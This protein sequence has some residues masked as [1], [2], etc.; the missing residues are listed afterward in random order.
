MRDVYSKA[1]L[2]IAATGAQSGDIGLFFGRDIELLTPVRIEATW[3][4]NHDLLHWPS[5]GSYLF[6]FHNV[7]VWKAIDNAPLN[8]RAWVAQERFLSKRTLHFTQSLLFWECP[9]SFTSENDA[10]ARTSLHSRLTSL[11]TRLNC[12]QWPDLDVDAMQDI[13]LDSTNNDTKLR[14]VYLTW[15]QFLYHYTSCG[16]TR[17]SDIL[18]ALV[19]VADE[20][21]HAMSD[22]MVA[23]LW[24]TR[25]IEELCWRSH[26]DTSRPIV[27]RAPSWSW[28]SLSNPVLP[29][30]CTSSHIPH[31]MAAVI[32]LCISK[33]SSGEV[34]QGSALIECRPI[35]ATVQYS[36]A[37]GSN[38]AYNALGT[39]DESVW[40]FSEKSNPER[41]GLIEVQLDDTDALCYH[42]DQVLDV[43]LLALLE[44]SFGPGSRI[45]LEGICVV[46]SEHQ[47]GAS[48]RVGSF[49]T[50]DEAAELVLA[51]YGRARVQAILLI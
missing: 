19:G 5:L 45:K 15:C 27:W 10:M 17:E 47:A 44:F 43:Q 39:L 40:A 28:A 3:L 50:F 9:T 2:C 24:K 13:T 14:E 42:D 31:E 16:I 46:D 25:F 35:S 8:R 37:E 18:V 26:G 23:G 21:G 6:G 38:G 51:A 1:D 49:Y 41:S 32:E 20:V 4:K 11:K 36:G 34:E 29:S 7:R 30:A 33:K 22:C 12:V 48:E